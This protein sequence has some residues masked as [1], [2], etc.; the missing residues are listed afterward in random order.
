MDP[1]PICTEIAGGPGD[2]IASSPRWRLRLHASPSPLAGWAIL[3]LRRHAATLD[4]LEPEEAAELG[5][6]VVRATAAIRGATG[7][8]RV[9]LLG[10]AEA[11]P[12]V[13]LHLAPRH[14]DD[15]ET[16]SWQVADLYRAVAAG[17]SPAAT[18]D[19]CE[20]VAAAMRAWFRR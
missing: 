7:C 6:W 4:L 18:L 9:Y 17:R 19:E 16:A 5:P 2:E 11:V 10:F 20:R 12:H 13:H 1:C 3:D 8:T 15:P 14:G